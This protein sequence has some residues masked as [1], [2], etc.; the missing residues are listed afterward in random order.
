MVGAGSWGTTI[1]ALVSQN[2]STSL[3]TRRPELADEINNRHTNSAYLGDY[4]LPSG[5]GASVHLEQLVKDADVIAM[6][7]PA[8]GFRHV[9]QQVA[10][11][12]AADVPIMSLSKG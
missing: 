12:V 11:Y 4:V 8:Q 3:W 5:L 10:R 9:A 1:A 7:V 6:A 2:A